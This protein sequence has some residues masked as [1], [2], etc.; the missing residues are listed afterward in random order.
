MLLG[1]DLLTQLHR[2]GE[3][4]VRALRGNR[5]YSWHSFLADEVGTWL[6]WAT[7]QADRL[8]PLKESPPSILDEAEK[9]KPLDQER[10]W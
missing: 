1:A 8:D 9:Y 4:G 6:R 10:F 3:L 2:A 7:D 5:K